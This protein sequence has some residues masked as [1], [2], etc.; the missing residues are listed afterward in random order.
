VVHDHRPRQQEL[1]VGNLKR[2]EDWQSRKYNQFDNLSVIHN[3]TKSLPLKEAFLYLE[4][5]P[6]MIFVPPAI[7]PTSNLLT[8]TL[9]LFADFMFT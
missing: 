8:A 3:T 5:S 1:T 4:P 6:V 9:F 7:Y 2:R